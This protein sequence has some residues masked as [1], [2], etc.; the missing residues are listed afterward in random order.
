MIGVFTKNS[1]VHI[2]KKT[3]KSMY[4]VT[5]EKCN[6]IENWTEVYVHILLSQG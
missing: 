6:M 1:F 3:T 4:I 2:K 5:K